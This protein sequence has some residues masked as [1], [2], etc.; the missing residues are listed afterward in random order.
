[1]GVIYQH[2]SGLVHDPQGND[3]SA[4]SRK[5]GYEPPV[6]VRR[7]PECERVRACHDRLTGE[8]CGACGA[9]T[10]IVGTKT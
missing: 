8:T 2:L 9:K 7:C 5:C 6:T 3:A 1:M 4:D 10:D